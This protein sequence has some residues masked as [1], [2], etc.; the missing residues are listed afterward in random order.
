MNVDKNFP[1]RYTKKTGWSFIIYFLNPMQEYKKRNTIGRLFTFIALGV[2]V[3]GLGM[4]VRNTEKN[5]HGV[6]TESDELPIIPRAHAS[7]G[8][9]AVTGGCACVTCTL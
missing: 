9:G 6:A 1:T 8:I 5:N 3:A 4:F 7:D 2:I